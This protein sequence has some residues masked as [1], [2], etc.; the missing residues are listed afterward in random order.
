[1]KKIVTKLDWMIIIVSGFVVF[2][3][4]WLAN[5]NQVLWWDSYLWLIICMFA[6]GFETNKFIKEIKLSKK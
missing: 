2:I 6:I 3:D 5:E 1:M 4:L